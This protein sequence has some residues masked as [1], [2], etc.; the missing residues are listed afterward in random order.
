[1]VLLKSSWTD[2]PLQPQFLTA[3]RARWLALWRHG[4]T[5]VLVGEAWH[6]SFGR[7]DVSCGIWRLH[8]V[9]R[10]FEIVARGNQPMGPDWNDM[11]EMFMTGNVNGHLWHV[12]PGAYYPHDAKVRPLTSTSD[13]DCGSFASQGE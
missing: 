2:L 3:D 6:A 12:I 10:E 5:V 4:I 13:S 8:P 1:M 7:I 11:G 9:T